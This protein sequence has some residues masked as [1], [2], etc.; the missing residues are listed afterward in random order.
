MQRDSKH[1]ETRILPRHEIDPVQWDGF[2]ARSPQGAN[3]AMTWYLDAVWPG[4]QGIHVFYKEQL[5]AVMPLRVSKK[6]GIRY[7][8]QPLL[9]QYLGVFLANI[10]LKNEKAWALKKRLVAA[11]ADAIP[12][13]LK[14]T[15]LN[16]APEF[17]YPLPF[18][19]AGYELRTRY[20]YWLD[21]NPDK[22]LLFRQ[23]NE[24][25][26]TYINK[27]RK[28]GL[29]ASLVEDAAAIIRLSRERN[30]YPLDYS[31][32]QK[33]WSALH[34]HGAGRAVEVRDGGGR[35]HGGLIYHVG[36]DRQIH[37]FSAMDPALGHLGGMSL[38]IWH[39]IEQA[40]DGVR[41]HDFEG[42]M[43]EPVEKF[44]RGFNTYPVPYLQIRKNNF[45][46][47]LRWMLED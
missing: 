23:L 38:A 30:A 39:S 13:G 3:Y 44:F 18:H 10:D 20:T 21:H 26:R 4:W 36:G 24:R 41:V 1:V 33:L 25:T 43:L 8:L 27:A 6:Y 34:E 11:V 47:P 7:C 22:Q 37:L 9:C 40:A 28:S 35:L 31:V 15:V 12:H 29:V 45:P 2:I 19:W 16:L 5:Y 42:S 17:D 32:L 46:K 14:K